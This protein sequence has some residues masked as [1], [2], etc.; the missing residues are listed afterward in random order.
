MTDSLAERAAL[1]VLTAHG[2]S[3]VK[4]ESPLT[5]LGWDMGDVISYEAALT[6][7]VAKAIELHE[8]ERRPAAATAVD[9]EVTHT[10]DEAG[11][12][13]YLDVHDPT[14]DAGDRVAP[15]IVNVSMTEFEAGELASA[16]TTRTVVLQLGEPGE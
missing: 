8:A 13:T 11:H 7:I 3:P 10:V 16:L 9:W 4:R 12:W 5:A 6:E 1:A 15:P 14:R 2:R